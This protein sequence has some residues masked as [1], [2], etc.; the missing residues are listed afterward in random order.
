MDV[1]SIVL[2][3]DRVTVGVRFRHQKGVVVGEVSTPA[4]VL[5]IVGGN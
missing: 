3:S 4:A 1:P 2:R 5:G